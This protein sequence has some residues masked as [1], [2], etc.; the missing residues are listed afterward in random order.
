MTSTISNT[1]SATKIT[2]SCTDS[3]LITLAPVCR[4]KA[5]WHYR[6]GIL[7]LRPD[8]VIDWNSD[9]LTTTERILSHEF[10]FPILRSGWEVFLNDL[11]KAHLPWSRLEC[12]DW[13]YEADR[14]VMPVSPKKYLLGGGLSK[15]V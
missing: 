1:I 12:S 2:L 4:S 8:G 6:Q 15:A 5:W 10:H 11:G 13:E 14:I 3:L 7:S 9:H